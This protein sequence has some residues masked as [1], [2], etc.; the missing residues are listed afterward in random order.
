M[1][2]STCGRDEACGIQAPSGSWLCGYCAIP[3]MLQHFDV[4]R[5]RI[6]LLEDALRK[7]CRRVEAGEIKSVNTYKE[8]KAILGEPA[9]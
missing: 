4:Q 8:F 7:F 1:K 5:N 2:C 6:N 3:D 9:E